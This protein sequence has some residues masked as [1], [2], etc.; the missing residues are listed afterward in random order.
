MTERII[1]VTP[2]EARNLASQALEL[3]HGP[4]AIP[5]AE[6]LEGEELWTLKVTPEQEEFLNSLDKKKFIPLVPAIVPLYRARIIAKTR[7]LP[8]GR[9]LHQA[10]QEAVETI[11]DPVKKA[12]AEESWGYANDV[13]RNSPVLALLQEIV[14]VDDAFVDDVFRDADNLVT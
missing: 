4:G 7:V 2:E 10:I 3:F 8:D 14:G 11:T 5:P 6:R 1:K 9:T 13:H 12:V